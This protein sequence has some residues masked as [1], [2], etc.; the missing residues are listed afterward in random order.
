VWQCK[1]SAIWKKKILLNVPLPQHRCSIRRRV[2]QTIAAAH[3]SKADRRAGPRCWRCASNVTRTGKACCRDR[4][5]ARA[6]A[7]H[8]TGRQAGSAGTTNHP[9]THRDSRVGSRGRREEPPPTGALGTRETRRARGGR[10][11]SQPDE[12]QR[13]AAVDHRSGWQK[14]HQPIGGGEM[15]P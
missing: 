7:S 10:R 2:T 4:A 3:Q 14:G 1:K 11:R 6:G 8:V 9:A 13:C 12:T 5:G 15:R